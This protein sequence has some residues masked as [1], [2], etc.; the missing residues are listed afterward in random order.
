MVQRQ[1]TAE[2]YSASRHGFSCKAKQNAFV[3]M[4]VVVGGGGETV[5]EK[6]G[7]REGERERG[8]HI[9]RVLLVYC[10]LCFIFSFDRHVI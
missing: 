4:C 9:V 1:E 3:G 8:R 10:S 7:E 6:E 5:R 2:R